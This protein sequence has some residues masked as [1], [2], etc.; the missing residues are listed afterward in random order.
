MPV[1]PVDEDASIVSRG[2]NRDDGVN[3]IEAPLR[4]DQ[5]TSRK[6]Q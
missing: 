2:W 6:Q 1:S 4:R 5:D 3:V